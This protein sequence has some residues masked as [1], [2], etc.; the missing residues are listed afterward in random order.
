MN[1]IVL[2]VLWWMTTIKGLSTFIVKPGL[3]GTPPRLYSK[4]ITIIVCSNL[5]PNLE[6]P[7]GSTGSTCGAAMDN[8]DRKWNTKVPLVVT[9]HGNLTDF[10]PEWIFNNLFLWLFLM[11][12]W[13]L[14]LLWQKFSNLLA[15]MLSNLKTHQLL[16]YKCSCLI[17][18]IKWITKEALNIYTCDLHQ[19]W[20]FRQEKV[21]R[22]ILLKWLKTLITTWRRAL[23]RLCIQLCR[24]QTVVAA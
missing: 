22:V 13:K 1:K 5:L 3:T 12:T 15:E 14:N 8:W 23:K 20:Q 24:H 18:V 16:K 9:C 11:N 21:P 7:K 19:N 17:V 4:K 10:L 2:R 6:I